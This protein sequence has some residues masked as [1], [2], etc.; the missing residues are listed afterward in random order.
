M[1]RSDNFGIELQKVPTSR[2]ILVWYGDGYEAGRLADV[3]AKFM[4]RMLINRFGNN[5]KVTVLRSNE[6]ST[7]LGEAWIV[8]DG[9][10]YEVPDSRIVAEIPFKVT[11][12]TL[13]ATPSVDPCSNFDEY[14][15]AHVLLTN[16]DVDGVIVN[17]W[18]SR[19][20]QAENA[21]S[22]INRFDELKVPKR[23]LRIF[24][25]KPERPIKPIGEYTELWLVPSKKH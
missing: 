10:D 6:K 16:P 1:A 4:H 2:G 12:R 7:L 23:R 13:F 20:N 3:F 24:F 21:A 22:I 9:V 17:V 15:F 14:G 11:E 8:P 5:L 25:R 18:L 19:S